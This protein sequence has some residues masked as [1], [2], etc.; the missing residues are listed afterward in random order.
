MEKVLGYDNYDEVNEL[1]IMLFIFYICFAYS[2]IIDAI[3]I[4]E[5]RIIMFLIQ[6][7]IVNLTI[8]PIYFIMYTT[9]YWIPSLKSIALMF[10]FGLLED[11][12]VDTF[13]LFIVRRKENSCLV[14]E[15]FTKQKNNL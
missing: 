10:G 6:T 14:L 9:K 12:I 5:G 2:S 8:Y 3:F 4:A 11:L 15:W 7:L 13:L 1:V